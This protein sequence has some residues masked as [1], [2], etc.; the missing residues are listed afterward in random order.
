MSDKLSPITYVTY[1][2][3]LTPFKIIIESDP[4]MWMNHS[5][6][7]QPFEKNPRGS[8]SIENSNSVWFAANDVGDELG[9]NGD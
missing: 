6:W 3:N 7:Y 2:P 5:E 1:D 4:W 8:V 9:R